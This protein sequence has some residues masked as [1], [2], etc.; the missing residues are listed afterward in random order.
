MDCNIICVYGNNKFRDYLVYN[1]VYEYVNSGIVKF[2]VVIG[3]AFPYYEYISDNIYIKYDDQ[4][5][6]DYLENI[7]TIYKKSNGIMDTSLLLID[8]NLIDLNTEQWDYILENYQI[9]K[10]NIVILM[11]KIMDYN[12]DKL[13]KYVNVVYILKQLYYNYDLIINVYKTFFKNYDK[14]KFIDSYIECTKTLYD[15]M[16]ANLNLNSIF[17]YKIDMTLPRFNFNTYKIYEQNKIY[18]KRCII[19]DIINV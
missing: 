6:E 14:K 5:M 12:I 3:K 11:D 19:S 13:N 4:V 10:I 18:R 16:I 9:Y 17:K 15:I 8:S 7:E 1:I 2:G